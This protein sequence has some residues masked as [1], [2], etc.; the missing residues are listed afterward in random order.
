MKK[1]HILVFIDVYE[2]GWVTTT[3]LDS[4]ARV[5]KHRR[6][7]HLLKKGLLQKYLH[8]NPITRGRKKIM[9]YR[10]SP[11]G[12]DYVLSHAF[13]QHLH[14]CTIK[15]HDE[16]ELLKDAVIAIDVRQ[17]FRNKERQLFIS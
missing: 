16:L 13:T 8:T 4:K 2:K 12:E 9:S 17:G 14:D 15:Q 1:E 11:H 7:E 3:N 6:L 5:Y 10:L